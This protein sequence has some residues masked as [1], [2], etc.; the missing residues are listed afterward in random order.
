MSNQM[1]SHSSEFLTEE[2]K[3][4]II[5]AAKDRLHRAPGKVEVV[6]MNGEFISEKPLFFSG[7]ASGATGHWG[8]L[9]DDMLLHLVFKLDQDKNPVGI[10]FERES[11]CKRWIDGGRVT[12]KE[13]I[14]ST[15]LPSEAFRAVAQILISQFGDYDDSI[16]TP[17][18]LLTFLYKLSATWNA[19]LSLH[20]LSRMTS[21]TNSSLFPWWLSVGPFCAQRKEITSR[22]SSKYPQR[23]CLGKMPWMLKSVMK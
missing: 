16:E 12:S 13:E 14:G 1:N 21:L 20:L 11:F 6:V 8:I 23:K 5:K 2:Q 10:R 4:S 15:S 22:K 19:R 7:W 18:H 9:A 17:R 3:Q